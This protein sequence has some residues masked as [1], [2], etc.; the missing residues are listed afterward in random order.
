MRHI[1]ETINC[2]RL[3][4]CFTAICI[5]LLSENP[6][7]AQDDFSLPP[8]GTYSQSDNA[9]S[10]LV[11]RPAGVSVNNTTEKQYSAPPPANWQPPP[12]QTQV[13]R[14]NVA[15][16]ADAPV[17]QASFTASLQPVSNGTAAAPPISQKSGRTAASIAIPPADST[18]GQHSAAPKGMWQSLVTT[19]FALMIVIGIFA[20]LIMATR[21][22]WQPT[23][24]NLPKDVFQVLGRSSYA[25]RQQVLVVRF[26]NKL[27]L[28]SHEIGNVQTLCEIDSQE[29]VD[30]ICGLCE[31]QSQSSI[32]ASFKSVLNQVIGAEGSN[33]DTLNTR[34][35]SSRLRQQM[36]RE[37]V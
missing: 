14:S 13:P 8:P 19:V 16:V 36:K 27:L 32:T 24:S 35:V 4:A 9:R 29:E 12:V 31:Q 17:Q 21:K 30:R 6:S 2:N 25:P 11:S 10:P 33:R 18:T 7:K 3:L 26:A 23:Q 15:A 28:V 22:K 5:L 1:T 34:S 20:V 37:A